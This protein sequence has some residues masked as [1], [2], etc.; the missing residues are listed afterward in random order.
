M[1]RKNQRVVTRQVT[2]WLT[3]ADV[4]FLRELADEREQSISAFLRRQ[5][6]SW[7]SSRKAG[8]I[9]GNRRQIRSDH[10]SA[11]K[12]VPTRYQSLTWHTENLII[13]L[14]RWAHNEWPDAVRDGRIAEVIMSDVSRKRFDYVLL[15][16]LALS[17]ATNV[18]VVG[19]VVLNQRA[20]GQP[21][22]PVGAKL[23]PI[24]GTTADGRSTFVSYGEDRPTVLYVYSPT[25]AWCERNLAAI[26]LL[27]KEAADRYRFVG[28]SLPSNKKEGSPALPF[29]AVL[30]NAGGPFRSTPQTLV[31]GSDGR[32]VKSWIGAYIGNTKSE[33]EQFFSVQLPNLD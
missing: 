19:T 31:I 20:Q 15:V 8:L 13:A 12:S 11:H 14:A 24:A 16:L 9:P 27:S 1:S 2:F 22:V 33:I 6:S 21:D 25:C 23:K 29:P 10:N 3:D 18:A 4:A 28:V 26:S 32:V 30:T 5:L 17:L 7:R